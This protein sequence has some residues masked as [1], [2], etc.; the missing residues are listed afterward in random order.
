VQNQ[1]TGEDD[2]RPS[3]DLGIAVALCHRGFRKRLIELLEPPPT[4]EPVAALREIDKLVHRLGE[5]D[6]K[7]LRSVLARVRW[8]G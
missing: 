3:F 5:H 6:S 1:L 7:A 4:L 8:V 2:K